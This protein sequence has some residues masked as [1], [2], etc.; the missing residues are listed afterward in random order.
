[1]LSW[2]PTLRPSG[3]LHHLR[4]V[5]HH[6]LHSSSL[7]T[8]TSKL[9]LV[10]SINFCWVT[11]MSCLF[12]QLWAWLRIKMKFFQTGEQDNS[13]SKMCVF[14]NHKTHYRSLAL[15]I[16]TYICLVS[17]KFPH[18]YVPTDTCVIALNLCGASHPSY[19]RSQTTY[20]IKISM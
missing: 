8:H 15:S 3:R 19:I 1:M 4:A 6:R 17:H 9:L 14:K 2:I 18:L 16:S 12:L 20:C 7:L 10:L 5:D 11:D 13:V